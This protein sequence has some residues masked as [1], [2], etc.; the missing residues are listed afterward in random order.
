MTTVK[1]EHKNHRITKLYPM[2]SF[3]VVSGISK[4]VRVTR[5]ENRFNPAVAF[6]HK[7]NFY[8]IV[9]I[10]KGKGWHEIDFHRYPAKAG[11][12]FF[13]LP[14]QVHSWF[15]SPA[16]T[17]IVIEFENL[18]ALAN[19]DSLLF[20]ELVNPGVHAIDLEGEE[21]EK[22]F[23]LV[24]EM[25]NEYSKE[26]SHFETILKMNLGKF[27]AFYYRF[28]EKINLAKDGEKNHSTSISQFRIQFLECLEKNYK[29]EHSVEFYAKIFNLSAKSLTAKVNRIIGKNVRDL[30]QER[31]LLESKRLLAYSDYS[32][33][34]I[35]SELGFEDPNYFTRLFR[36]KLNSTPTKFRQKVRH[37]H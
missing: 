12:V 20:S 17:G 27:L 24:D 33:N 2:T 10:T 37:I 14:S 3:G 4:Q 8:H 5:L 7:H 32:I 15:F 9:I 19:D 21:K 25:I 26:E 36:L 35:S 28:C 29:K 31:C 22:I 16:T 18:A 1:K 34:E 6:P 11:S 13:M 30:I 23:Q